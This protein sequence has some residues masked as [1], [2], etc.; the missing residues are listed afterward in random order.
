MVNFDGT[1]VLHNLGQLLHIIHIVLF[2]FLLCIFMMYVFALPSL[3]KC[4]NVYGQ[5]SCVFFPA[6]YL[7]YLNVVYNVFHD[8]P[9]EGHQP[10]CVSSTIKVFCILQVLSV[11]SGAF[12]T[13][14]TH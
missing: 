14:A 13:T 4:V 9:D 5:L 8:D 12:Q 3:S 10:K 2:S 7:H 1:S 6:L 11:L